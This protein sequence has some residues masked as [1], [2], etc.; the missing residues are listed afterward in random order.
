MARRTPPAAPSGPGTVETRRHPFPFVPL[1]AGRSTE[2]P[3]RRGR[4][5]MIDWG[6]DLV[7]QGQFLIMAGRFI[8]IAKIPVGTARL[9]E[10]SY[11]FSKLALYRAHGVLTY[12]GGGFVE[13]V[14]MTQGNRSLGRFFAE[15]KRLG[16]DVV[17]ISDNYIPLSRAEK[18]AQMRIALDQGLTVYG[19]VGSKHIKNDAATLIRQA[20]ECFADGA[21][22]VLLEGGEFVE[23]GRV[24]TEM[25]EALKSG[26]DLA[27]A[28]VEVPGTWNSGA[29]P[30]M[31]HDLKKAFVAAFGPDVNLGNIMPDEI[32]ET[33][34]LRCGLG[35]VQ[36]TERAGRKAG[37][38]NRAAPGRARKGRTTR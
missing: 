10:E 26:L 32:V 5:L 38:T 27:R 7:R 31:I 21:D 36:P 9:Y 33:E 37:G 20:K 1:A 23:D 11:L 22:T 30:S 19:E 15:A 28:I 3:R 6:L 4:T 12:V 2:K 16:F 17:E 18:A 25:V 13:H 29:E 34:A 8:D 24:K 35:V 14:A